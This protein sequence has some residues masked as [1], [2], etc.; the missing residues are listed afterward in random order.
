MIWATIPTIYDTRGRREEGI[1]CNLLRTHIREMT[2]GTLR[3][4]RKDGI[5]VI[6]VTYEDDTNIRIEIFLNF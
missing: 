2:Y 4:N 5:C 3:V 1:Y 6:R